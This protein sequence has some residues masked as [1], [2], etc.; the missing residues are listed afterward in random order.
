MS[1]IADT[2]FVDQPNTIGFSTG[3]QKPYSKFVEIADAL[4]EFIIQF[5]NK[6]PYYRGGELH[7]VGE[8]FT[9]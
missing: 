3:S 8:S 9:G 6:F 2:V 1:N 7:I 4:N 5:Y